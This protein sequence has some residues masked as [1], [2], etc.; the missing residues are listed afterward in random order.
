M[1]EV[2]RKIAICVASI[3]INLV[4][5]AMITILILFTNNLFLNIILF[6]LMF[7]TL[8]IIFEYAERLGKILKEE[9]K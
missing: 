8:N 3:F 2:N 1:D 7:I 4:N 6:V 9:L 5:V